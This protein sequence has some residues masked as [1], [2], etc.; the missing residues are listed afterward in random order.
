MAIL[1]LDITY[2][3]PEGIVLLRGRSNVLPKRHFD[4]GPYFGLFCNAFSALWVA[5][6][7]VLFCLPEFLPV[8]MGNM[9]YVS[10][11]IAGVVCAI[12]AFYESKNHSKM[13]SAPA[14][15]Y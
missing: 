8:T 14:S 3:V 4:L 10:V 5:L 11:V 9:N 15:L 7:T 2:V 1:S 12:G 6:Y 13:I